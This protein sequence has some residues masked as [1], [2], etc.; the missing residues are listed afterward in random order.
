LWKIVSE[1]FR[2]VKKKLTHST[3]AP[4]MLRQNGPENIGTVLAAR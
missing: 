1:N 3:K 2:D 4:R